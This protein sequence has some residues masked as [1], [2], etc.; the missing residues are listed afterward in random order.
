MGGTPNR[1]DVLCINKRMIARGGGFVNCLAFRF[2]ALRNGAFWC[3][4]GH[5]DSCEAIGYCEI[6]SAYPSTSVSWVIVP[7]GLPTSL[8]RRQTWE[9][10]GRKCW[11]RKEYRSKNA[12]PVSLS[13]SVAFIMRKPLHCISGHPVIFIATGVSQRA[14]KRVSFKIWKKNCY[15]GR[16]LKTTKDV[17][18]LRSFLM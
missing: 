11:E 12:Q 18:W 13:R 14:T 16:N 4:D 6:T 17:V 5:F 8:L 10:R 1:E 9:R 2:L 15:G 7:E 3:R